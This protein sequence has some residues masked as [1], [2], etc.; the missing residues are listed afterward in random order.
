MDNSLNLPIREE[1]PENQLP[2]MGRFTTASYG[3][4]QHSF[5]SSMISSFSLQYSNSFFVIASSFFRP[6][7]TYCWVIT[8][9]YRRFLFFILFARTANLIVE[10]VQRVSILQEE[11]VV[12]ML[13]R[14]KPFRE[15]FRIRVNLEFLYGMCSAELVKAD[16]TFPRQ[17]SERFIF[18]A[19]QRV[20]P[21]TPLFLIF[22]LPARSMKHSL[23]L[24]V[25]SP[26]V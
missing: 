10:R 26:Q 4:Y 18:F 13:V 15:S 7:I 8:E 14:E 16:T 25:L 3:I 11:H 12:I 21:L 19:Y 6:Y 1:T 20:W 24:Y 2:L 9:F 17:E 5:S 22:Q 23:F